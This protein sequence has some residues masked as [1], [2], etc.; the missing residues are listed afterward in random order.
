MKDYMNEQRIPVVWGVDKNYVL[1]AFVVMRS[2][3]LNSQERY[4]FVLLTIDSIDEEV[5]K[6]TVILKREYNNFEVSVI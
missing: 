6:F 3:L 5:E 2:I 4:Q 1:Q